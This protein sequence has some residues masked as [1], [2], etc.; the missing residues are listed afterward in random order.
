MTAHPVQTPV[1]ASCFFL[2]LCSHGTSHPL[3]AGL[4]RQICEGLK[5]SANA[6]HRPG[7]SPGAVRRH[8][9]MQAFADMKGIAVLSNKLPSNSR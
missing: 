8:R 1:L 2:S 6:L 9:Q 5:K 3:V 4:H 7:E